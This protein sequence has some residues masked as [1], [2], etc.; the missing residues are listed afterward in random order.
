MSLGI[1]QM[2]LND[3]VAAAQNAAAAGANQVAQVPV[4]PISGQELARCASI[5]RLGGLSLAMP[6]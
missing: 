6:G 3:A 4:L 1:N 5:P 2:V